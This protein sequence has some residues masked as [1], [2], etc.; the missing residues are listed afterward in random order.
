[1]NPGNTYFP[2]ASTTSAP[3]GVAGT[4]V[5]SP[6]GITWTLQPAPTTATLNAVVYG[7]QYV[8]VGANGTVLTSADGLAW[9]AQVSGTLNNLYAI[10]HA[11]NSYSAVGAGGANVYSQ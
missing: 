2:L 3:V 9:T 1:M 7:S 4:L 6:N 10:E 11:P 5:T 8:A